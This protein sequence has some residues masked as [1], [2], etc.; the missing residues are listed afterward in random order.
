MKSNFL[1]VSLRKEKYDFF[2]E[3]RV[4]GYEVLNFFK[5]LFKK[6]A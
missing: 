1:S 3:M 4:K 6:Y 2:I 5:K